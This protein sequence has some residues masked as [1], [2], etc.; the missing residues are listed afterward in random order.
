MS[1]KDLVRTFYEHVISENRL[2]LLADYVAASCRLVSG[3]DSQ[4][5]GADGMA[6]HIRA[7]K[8]TYPD[9]TLQILRQFCDGETVVSEFLMEGT[10]AG[11][12]LGI[13]PTGRK[14]SF[15]GINIDR[16]RGGKIVEHSGAVNTFE[17]LLAEHLIQPA[18]SGRSNPV[19]DK[20][21]PQ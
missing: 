5:L 17:T 13:P 3:R 14:L 1:P 18:S 6:E 15:T 21:S 19:H 7:T 12:W 4:P 8:Q 9:Y 20:E 2:D 11:V 16:V 10:H